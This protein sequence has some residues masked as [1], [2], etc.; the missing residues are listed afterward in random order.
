MPQIYTHIAKLQRQYSRRMEIMLAFA[1]GSQ[2]ELRSLA[3]DREVWQRI[4]DPAWDWEC[5]D[6]RVHEGGKT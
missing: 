6:Y 1:K 2:I 4:D 3:C 5:F